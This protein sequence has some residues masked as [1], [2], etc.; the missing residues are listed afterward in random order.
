MTYDRL[1]YARYLPYYYAQMSQLPTSS[2]DVH[3]E[4]MQGGFLFQLGCNNPFGRIPV[5]QTIEET[6]NKDTARWTK[7]FSLEPGAVS[8]YYLVAEYGAV[9]LKTLSDMIGRCSSK[10]HHP[11]RQ[12]PRI[13][14]DEADIK[15]LIDMMENNWLNTLSPDESDLVSLYTGHVA[16]PAMVKDLLG[17][18]EVGEEAYNT[19]KRTIL[20]DDPPTIREISR[21]NDEP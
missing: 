8:R 21:Q 5:E 4:F 17:A 1:N 3:A 18:L 13:R 19:F 2:P 15:S 9:Y 20:D 10:L 11:D 6:V 12:G 14:K 16:P 7:G